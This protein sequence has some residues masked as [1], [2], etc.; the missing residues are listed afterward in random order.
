MSDRSGEHMLHPSTPGSNQA[1]A[2]VGSQDA[3]QFISPTSEKCTSAV[4][5]YA[6]L[7]RNV[8]TVRSLVYNLAVW[9][10]QHPHFLIV[11]TNRPN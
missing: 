10:V 2:S 9:H 4:W 8:P 1:G 5:K 3:P 6:H 11:L 7:L